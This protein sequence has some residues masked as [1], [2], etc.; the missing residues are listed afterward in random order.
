MDLSLDR[1]WESLMR[2]DPGPAVAFVDLLTD[3]DFS[4]AAGG[5]LRDLA[6]RLV[7]VEQYVEDAHQREQLVEAIH[8]VLMHCCDQDSAEV[9][10]LLEEA[11]NQ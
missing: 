8:A 9:D 11:G 1:I 10:R 6:E 4:F 5:L 3:C 7:D 2:G